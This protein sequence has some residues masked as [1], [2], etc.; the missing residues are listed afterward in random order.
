MHF[1]QKK[2]GQGT[3]NTSA[4]GPRAGDDVGMSGKLAEMHKEILR[5]KGPFE[6]QVTNLKFETTNQKN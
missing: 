2:A 4:G 1:V 5:L 6:E 3:T